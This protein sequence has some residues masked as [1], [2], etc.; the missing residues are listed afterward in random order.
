MEQDPY[1][2]NQIRRDLHTTRFGHPIEYRERVTS[3][4]DRVM[5]M[6]LR[7]APEGTV[8]LAEEQT[9]GRGRRG[10]A[11]YSPSR[12]GVWTSF[13][14]RPRISGRHLPTLT[15]CAAHVVAQ[16][17]EDVTKISPCVKW[18]NDILID[19]RKVAGILGEAKTMPREGPCV[20][21]GVGVN[22]NQVLEDFPEDLQT[23]A[24]SLRIAAGK[25][26]SRHRF[27]CR[28]VDTFEVVYQQYLQDGLAPFLPTLSRRLA[29]HGK[30]VEVTEFAQTTIGT[31]IDLGEDGSLVLEKDDQ[32]RIA[33]NS[34]SLRLHI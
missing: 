1:D 34:G 27:F 29:W 17:I 14:L 31:V 11:W 24:T 4:N 18:P 26:V 12:A 19:N 10:A 25:S 15:L 28:L 5:D 23:T 16:T 32:T 6:A 8:A 22:V 3:T 20:V 33:I 13:L 7:G 2:I 30:T 9:A 21:I